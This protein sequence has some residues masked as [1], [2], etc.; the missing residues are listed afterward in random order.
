MP[1]MAMSALMGRVSRKAL[2]YMTYTC[3]VIDADTALSFGLASQVVPQRLAGLHSTKVPISLESAVCVT[4]PLAGICALRFDPEPLTF[5][6]TLGALVALSKA[7]FEQEIEAGF[8]VRKLAE[9]LG[10]SEWLRHAYCIADLVTYGKGIH[11]QKRG[12]ALMCFSEN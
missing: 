3:D 1:T 8:V 2:M 6:L 5:A 7:D 9:E 10:G 11:P 4:A 12:N